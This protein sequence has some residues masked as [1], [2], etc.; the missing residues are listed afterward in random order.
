MLHLLFV[1]LCY[2]T[3]AWDKVDSDRSLVEVIKKNMS[4]PL[5]HACLLLLKTP[6]DAYC[7]MIKKVY[8]LFLSIL[9]FNIVC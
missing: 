2:V 3:E 4:G 8:M 7:E 1:L 6:I 9:I 5:E